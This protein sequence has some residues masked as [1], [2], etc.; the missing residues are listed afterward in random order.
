MSACLESDT[1]TVSVRFRHAIPLW[2]SEGKCGFNGL[3]DIS[4]C[5]LACLQ[6]ITLLLFVRFRHAIPF[7]NQ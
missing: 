7:W 5:Q 4:I 1:L 2:K 3:D 6:N